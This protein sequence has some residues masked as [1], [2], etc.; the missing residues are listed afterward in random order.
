[1]QLWHGTPHAALNACAGRRRATRCEYARHFKF[2]WNARAGY[3]DVSATGDRWNCCRLDREEHQVAHYVHVVPLHVRPRPCRQKPSSRAVAGAQR[4]DRAHGS[5]RGRD[6]CD[7][8]W[9]PRGATDGN[10]PAEHAV[11]SK[12][13]QQSKAEDGN[14]VTARFRA[15]RWRNVRGG[16]WWHEREGDACT[17]DEVAPIVRDAN[18]G[19]EWCRRANGHRHLASHE[20][21]GVEYS[22]CW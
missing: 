10:T 6:A 4:D 14:L 17:A 9:C 19:R 18:V 13:A 21:T 3:S 12:L 20:A 11:D 2:R 16:C 8:R 15:C 7:S 22:L 5:H 1:M